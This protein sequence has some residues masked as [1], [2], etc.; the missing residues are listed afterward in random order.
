M[1][2]IILATLLFFLW[3]CKKNNRIEPI[4]FTF[5]AEK[6]D[7]ITSQSKRV[8]QIEP[9]LNDT[10]FENN[11]FEQLQT[12]DTS[13][14]LI[15]NSEE[16]RKAV[17]ENSFYDI[18]LMTRLYYAWKNDN[19]IALQYGCGENCWG[20]MIFPF[21]RES[22]AIEILYP[23][24]YDIKNNLVIYLEKNQR[25]FSL[26]A[27]NLISRENQI[28]DLKI[29]CQIDLISSCVDSIHFKDKI[30]YLEWTVNDKTQNKLKRHIQINL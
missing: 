10:I 13:F 17:K 4:I 18:N 30:F 22:K 23:F 12:S 5:P 15:W 20:A 6:N 1:R 14:L 7:S 27:E 2:K 16:F 26:I 21:R 24:A 11:S 19:F 29:E 9:D 25:D 8:I 3:A 28:I